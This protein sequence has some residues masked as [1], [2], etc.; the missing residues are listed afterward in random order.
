MKHTWILDK[1]N[2]E[3]QRGLTIDVTTMKF[4]TDKRVYTVID[5]PGHQDYINNMIC[6]VQQAEAA[7]LIVSANNFEKEFSKNGMVREHAL[8]AASMGV[9]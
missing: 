6:G 7:L 3:R 1:S 4:E 5:T 9:K 8:L 2:A